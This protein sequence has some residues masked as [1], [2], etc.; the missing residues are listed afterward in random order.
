MNTYAL[1]N[2]IDLEEEASEEEYCVTKRYIVTV[3]ADFTFD[4]LIKLWATWGRD[5]VFRATPCNVLLRFD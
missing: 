1:D 3:E 2:L 4:P 5:S